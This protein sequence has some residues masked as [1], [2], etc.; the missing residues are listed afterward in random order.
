MGV[1]LALRPPGAQRRLSVCLPGT[2]VLAADTK[3]RQQRNSS[4]SWAPAPTRP[5]LRIPTPTAFPTLV[6]TFNAQTQF[7]CIS[8]C[9]SIITV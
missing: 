2:W 3:V 7:A 8:C 4:A 1:L 5:P 9:K 6:F